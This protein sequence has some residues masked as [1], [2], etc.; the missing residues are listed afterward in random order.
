MQ[1]A[2]FPPSTTEHLYFMCGSVISLVCLLPA[3]GNK[4]E[5]TGCLWLP[6]K[7]V[8][9]KNNEEEQL[10]ITHYF[11]KDHCW[12]TE[13]TYILNQMYLFSVAE[14][15]TSLMLVMVNSR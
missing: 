9:S 12:V 4:T 2:N 14:Q 11:A 7:T 8:R 3:Q 15:F 6:K 10:I 13:T 1:E 5:P